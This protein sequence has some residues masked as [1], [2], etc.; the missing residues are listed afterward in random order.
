MDNKEMIDTFVERHIGRIYEDFRLLKS[1]EE[2]MQLTENATRLCVAILSTFFGYTY[3][4]LAATAIDEA[5][6]AIKKIIATV[7]E[8][9]IESLRRM[10]QKDNNNE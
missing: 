3:T 9:V 2:Y 8:L 7:S 6:N 4:K 1:Q 10:H 5:D